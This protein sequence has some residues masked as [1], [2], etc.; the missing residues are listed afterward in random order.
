MRIFLSH[1]SRDKALLRELRAHFP[2]WIT[3]WMD[4]ER[5]LFG[6][7]LELSL[8]NAINAEVD[9]VVL[10]LGLE[11]LN[12]EWVKQEIRWALAREDELNRTI[13]LPVLLSDVRNQLN[14]LGL[15]GRLTLECTDYS[16]E[17]IAALATKMAN[18]LGGWLSESLRQETDLSTSAANKRQMITPPPENRYRQLVQSVTANL[19]SLPE[20]WQHLVESLL[21]RPFLRATESSRR[22]KIP[23][24]PS[25]YYQCILHEIGLAQKGW[26]VLAVSTLS[27]DLWSDDTNQKNYAKR[28]LEA[29]KREAKIRRLFILPEGKDKRFIDTIRTQ[30]DSGVK[31]RVANTK[32]LAETADLEDFVIFRS[33]EYM[34]AYICYPA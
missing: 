13:L 27:S 25:Q 33:P 3:V 22:G 11:A 7:N 19:N 23:L 24:N 9:Y 14:D 31:I 30:A 16:K 5:L 6:S 34:H 32:L 21:L 17:G 28:N 12:S 8:Q 29:V 20:D 26:E 2:P 10:F 15:I 18:N 4:E 1:S